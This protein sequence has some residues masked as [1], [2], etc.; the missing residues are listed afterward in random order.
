V[1]SQPYRA[2]AFKDLEPAAAGVERRQDAAV[3]LIVASLPVALV[4]LCVALWVFMGA[5]FMPMAILGAAVGY[6][7]LVVGVCVSD[8]LRGRVG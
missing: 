5:G 2:H 7:A 8:V 6:A 3:L 1:P 4:A